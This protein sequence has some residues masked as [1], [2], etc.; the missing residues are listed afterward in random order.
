M[1][2]IRPCDVFWQISFSWLR[3][4][5]LNI[6]S[7]WTSWQMNRPLSHT[8]GQRAVGRRGINSSHWGT[9]VI[10]RKADITRSISLVQLSNVAHVTLSVS[11]R[12]ALGT[13]RPSL[14]R[15]QLCHYTGYQHAEHAACHHGDWHVSLPSIGRH[16]RVALTRLPGQNWSERQRGV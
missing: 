13:G 4:F 15:P 1:L 5:N 7:G 16:S 11:L 8:T 6:S 9:L 12:R 2:V 3:C 10:Y 14:S